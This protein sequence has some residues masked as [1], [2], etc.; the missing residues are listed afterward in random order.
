VQNGPRTAKLWLVACVGGC[1]VF[2]LSCTRCIKRVLVGW[3]IIAP[4]TVG[5]GR[6][7][8]SACVCQRVC[9]RVLCGGRRL[10]GVRPQSLLGLEGGR[11]E[12]GG[13]RPDSV[14]GSADFTFV[15]T[16]CGTAR[17]GNITLRD[18]QTLFQGAPVRNTLLCQAACIKEICP[19]PACLS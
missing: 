8:T 15:D 6:E 16:G 10:Q 11:L 9:Q 14:D 1:I 3:A 13:L 17:K 12:G 7:A 4:R 2:A 5:G 19:I 18:R